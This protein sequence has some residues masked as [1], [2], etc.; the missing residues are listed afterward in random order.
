MGMRCWVG[1]LVVAVLSVGFVGTA[2]SEEMQTDE[3]PAV[4]EQPGSQKQGVD[5]F[6]EQHLWAGEGVVIGIGDRE[7]APGSEAK[8][9][10]GQ[11][12]DPLAG[13]TFYQTVDRTDLADEY[14]RSN[15]IKVGVT[16]GGA[17][18]AAVGLVVLL[19]PLRGI[20]DLDDEDEVHSRLWTSFI[21]AGITLTGAISVLVGRGMDPH[22][23][24]PGERLEMAEDYNRA[25]LDEL[26]LDE[27]ELPEEHGG[28]LRIEDFG[29]SPFAD[30]QSDDG[31]VGGGLVI[32]GR[33]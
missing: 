32:G 17:A 20:F 3:E 23:V 9:Y 15:N 29:V 4:D 11:K 18:V 19:V 28:R 27:D 7:I 16:W 13:E 1:V 10:L 2:S 12:Q 31:S 21:G 5:R 24:G 6:M 33:F 25:L 26:E 22:P 8:I 14:R 30:V